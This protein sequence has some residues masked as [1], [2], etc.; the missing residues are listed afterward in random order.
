MARTVDPTTSSSTPVD[1]IAVDHLDPPQEPPP[2]PA[3]QLVKYLQDVTIVESIGAD[4]QLKSTSFFYITASDE[5]YFGGTAENKR[6][7]TIPEINAVLQR[8]PDEDIYAKL[9][10]DDINNIELTL[11]RETLVDE[12]SIYVKRPGLQWYEDMIGT[13]YCPK[14]LLD[15]T[16]IMETISK[17]PHPNIVRYHRCRVQRGYITSIV[18]KWLDKTLDQYA[19]T[20]GFDKLDKVNFFDEL[21][22][23][24]DYL[25]SLGLAHNDPNPQNIMV[26]EEEDGSP[27]LIDFDSCQP[28]G[29][30]LQ[31][32]G[33]EGWYENPFFTSE[34]EHDVYI[35]W[36]KSKNG[37][38]LPNRWL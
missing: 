11:A 24:V 3:P 7:V 19:S 18:L 37:S 21:K 13:G 17:T 32:S 22:P 31:P 2:L 8:V 12:S 15:E 35:L 33:T 25:H 9:P 27:V 36:R 16:M 5:V 38:T 14:A 26:R 29:K 28:F 1:E 34:K 30:R 23:A 6:E 4:G 20:P 10:T